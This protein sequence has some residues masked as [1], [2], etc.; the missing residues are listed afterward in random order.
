MA[1]IFHRRLAI[2]LWAIACLTV[3]LAPPAAKLLLPPTLVVIALAGI[4]VLVFSKPRAF[5]WLRTSRLLARVTPSN[6]RDQ[7]RMAALSSPLIPFV[8]FFRWFTVLRD[9]LPQ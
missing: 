7:M 5:P 6:C 8:R 3:A 9:R 4:A 2:P 1:L